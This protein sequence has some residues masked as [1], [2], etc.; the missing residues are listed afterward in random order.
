MAKDVAQGMI[1]LI[2]LSE[3]RA[4]AAPINFQEARSISPRALQKPDINTLRQS[5]F[6]ARLY[7]VLAAKWWGHR[8]SRG[9]NSLT[10]T[11]NQRIT[12]FVMPLL[13]G[14]VRSNALA[15]R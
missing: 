9:P 1:A 4:I 12:L 15:C 10:I 11:T 6:G 7:T 14:R 5:R 3:A 2:A 13:R 8:S